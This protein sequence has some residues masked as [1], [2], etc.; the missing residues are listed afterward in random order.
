MTQVYVGLV[1]ENNYGKYEV[2]EK[3]AKFKYKVVFE[4]TGAVKVVDRRSITANNV[5]DYFA[6]SV[7]GIGFIGNSQG[8]TKQNVKAYKTWTSMLQRCYSE[9]SLKWAPTYKG[10]T[11]CSEWHDFTNFLVWFNEN[12]QEGYE[13]DK[14]VV[15]FGNKVYSPTTCKFIPESENCASTSSNINVT[16]FDTNRVEYCKIN[17]LRQFCR[18]RELVYERMQKLING[19]KL[20]VGGYRLVD[21]SGD[22]KRTPAELLEEFMNTTELFGSEGRLQKIVN[23]FKEGDVCWGKQKTN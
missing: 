11:V 13:L 6:P 1:Q 3:V 15:L 4:N 22:Y 23:T 17:N 14:D 10:V 19:D 20:D 7:Y 8:K 12:Y 2:I 21:E 9:K 18:E 5:K 16:L